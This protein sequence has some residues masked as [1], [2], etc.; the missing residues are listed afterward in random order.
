MSENNITVVGAGKT[1]LPAASADLIRKSM[2]ARTLNDY[3]ED[4]FLRLFDT[5]ESFRELLD[6]VSNADSVEGTVRA[7][8][9]QAA[10]VIRDAAQEG[11][12]IKGKNLEAIRKALNVVM[13][14]YGISR[15]ERKHLLTGTENP[16][17]EAPQQ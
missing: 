17:L 4:V 3:V 8:D 12:P 16:V 6:G 10:R 14:R 15:G 9:Y 7:D 1:N 5:D 13:R 2:R 11:S